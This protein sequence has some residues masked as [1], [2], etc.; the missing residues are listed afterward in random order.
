MHR[1]SRFAGPH[2]DHWSHG[3]H[4][5]PPPDWRMPRWVTLWFPVVVAFVI[6]VP[7][8]TWTV[9][10]TP[11]LSPGEAASLVALAL[12]G[13][14]ALIGARRFPGPVVV[15]VALAGALD[16]FLNGAGG[17][18]Y[19]ALAFAII[20]AIVRG[21][22][23]WAWA[24]VGACWVATIVV[25]LVLDNVHWPPGRVAGTTLGI[26]IVF[27]IGEG[28]RTRRERYAEYRRLATQREQS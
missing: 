4:G 8:A 28:L 11:G 9:R 5:P 2:P 27:G 17:P 25:A 16:I 1:P 21:A 19:V 3:W 23:V 7:F 26:L 10:A 24:A 13:P 12:V 20:G 14:L 18:P 22:R 6:Q 15:V